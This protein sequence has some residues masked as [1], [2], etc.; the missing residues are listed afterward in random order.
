MKKLWNWIVAYFVPTTITEDAVDRHVAANCAPRVH[1]IVTGDEVHDPEFSA[2]VKEELNKAQIGIR[3]MKKAQ[4][5]RGGDPRV[6]DDM[7]RLRKQR[8]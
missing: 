5:K 3:A 4:R 2:R 7:A 6:H 1:I 8:K